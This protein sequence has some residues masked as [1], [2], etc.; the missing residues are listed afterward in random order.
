LRGTL[1]GWREALA[2]LE[3]LKR[4]PAGAIR[5]VHAERGEAMVQSAQALC[6]VAP[7]EGGLL[8]DSIRME[9]RGSD[10]RQ[11]VEILAGGPPLVARSKR[12]KDYA[13]EV[14]EDLTARHKTGQA[15]FVEI[16]FIQIGLR[17]PDEV[18]RAID[19]IVAK[20]G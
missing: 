4:A 5:Q 6:P 2:S 14:H 13:A 11:S 9:L 15:K 8:R 17:I 12:G 10:E 7:E 16:P 19:K 18:V 20:E 1:V 3:R